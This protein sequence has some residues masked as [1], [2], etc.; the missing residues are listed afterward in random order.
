[1]NIKIEYDGSY[2]NLCRGQLIV[3]IDEKRWDFG[4]HSLSSGGS[5]WFDSDWNEHVGS[6]FWTVSE[7]PKDF[8][9]SL[10]EAVTDAINNQIS[11]GCCGGCV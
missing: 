6:G 9:D 1:M 4:F 11:Y 5:V 3:T 8:P 2:P 10:K 7:W